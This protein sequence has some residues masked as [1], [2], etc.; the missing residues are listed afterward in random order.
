VKQKGA[1]KGKKKKKLSA[2]LSGKFNEIS[3]ADEN[4]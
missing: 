2:Q 1:L 3:S 4:K